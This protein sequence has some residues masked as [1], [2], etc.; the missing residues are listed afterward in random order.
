MGVHG[1]L[2]DS[3]TKEGIAGAIISV[4]AIGHDI[5]SAKD[6]DYWRLLL[7]GSYNLSVQHPECVKHGFC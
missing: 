5:K 6:G 2:T 7:P 4:A 1:F 3:S